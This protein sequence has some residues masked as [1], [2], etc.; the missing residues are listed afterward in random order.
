MINMIVA[1]RI[2]E[3]LKIRIEDL[4]EREGKTVSDLIRNLL[5]NYVKTKEEEWQRIRLNVRIPKKSSIAGG[6]VHR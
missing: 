6:Y 2:P 4:C 1:A 3:E 5:E